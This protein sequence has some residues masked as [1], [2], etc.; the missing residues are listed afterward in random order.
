MLRILVWVEFLNDKIRDISIQWNWLY[1]CEYDDEEY[2]RIYTLR[3][4]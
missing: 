2:S 4:W 1:E 3:K